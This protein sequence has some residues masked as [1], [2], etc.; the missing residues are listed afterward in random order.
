MVLELLSKGIDLQST[1][2]GHYFE[3]YK[4]PEIFSNSPKLEEE[5][6]V[7]L[8]ELKPI[9]F[10]SSTHYT[11]PSTFAQPREIFFVYS[12]PLFENKEEVEIE[13]QK[14]VIKIPFKNFRDPPPSSPPPTITP[15]S[16]PSDSPFSTSSFTTSSSTSSIVSSSSTSSNMDAFQPI[17][18]DRYAS[19]HLP[20]Q[21]NN[22]PDGYLKHLPR[23]N[24]ETCLSVEDHLTAF[25]GSV[26][27]MNIEH[28]DVYMRSFVQSLEGN[29]MIWFRQL[30][31]DSI[32]SWNELTSIFKN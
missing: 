18:Q 8:S 10:S 1:L 30:R 27:N 23:F 26:D 21:L 20:D 14:L 12:N 19:L 9:D 6:D 24:G 29:I 13:V 3:P 7:H 15:P 5:L 16:S 2:L 4:I 28:E 25:L 17:I 31:D 32:H 22:F 11:F